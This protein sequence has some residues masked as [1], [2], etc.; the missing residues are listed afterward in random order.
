MKIKIFAF[1]II[2]LLVLGNVVVL[3]AVSEG[4][5][6]AW[7]TSWIL[8]DTDP[9]ESGSNN[10]YKDVQLASYYYDDNYLYFRLECFGSPNFTIEHESRY[11]WFIDTDNP[12]NMA[13]SRW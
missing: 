4:N 9:N 8:T 2:I 12:Y 1:G 3:V 13:W 10:D 11:K 7:P 5:Q 6:P